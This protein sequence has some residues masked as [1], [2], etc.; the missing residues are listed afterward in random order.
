MSS[1]CKA[2][3]LQKMA[4]NLVQTSAPA[5]VKSKKYWFIIII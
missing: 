2:D 3:N 4:N 5:Q 1:M